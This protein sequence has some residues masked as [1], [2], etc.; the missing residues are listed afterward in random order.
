[1]VAEPRLQRNNLI[2]QHRLRIKIY[3]QSLGS[4]AGT[5]AEAVL[6]EGRRRGG[7]RRAAGLVD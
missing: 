6:Q 7:G 4:A 2:P 3:G 5:C 1:M